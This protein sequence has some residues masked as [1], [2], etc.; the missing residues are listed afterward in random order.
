M[1]FVLDTAELPAGDRIE[2]VHAAMQEASAPCYVI[3]EDP[4]G[5]VHAL[6]GVWELG[7][8][9]IFTNRASGIRLSRTAKQAKQDVEPVVALSVQLLADGR[10]EQLSAREVVKPGE[11]MAMDLSAPYEFSWSGTG[12]AGC[13]QIRF[14]QLGLPVDVI[15]DATG[16]LR[17]SPLNR[18]F[19]D[20][21]SHLVA[22]AGRLSADA[23]AAA[24]GTATVELARALLISAAHPGRHTAEVLHQTL[25]TRVR[26]Y[27][28]RHLTDPALRPATIAAAH[29]VSLRYL[30]KIC[31]EAGF[32]L[33]QWIIGERLAGARADLVRPSS[34]GHTIAVIARRWGFSDP[35]HFTRRFRAAYDITPGEWR[36][37]GTP[38]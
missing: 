14:E 27:V 30:Y 33:E 7:P 35:T 8:A 5:D 12:A 20:H 17:A 32:S 19:T 38:R 9:N 29:N 34:R 25:L 21:V 13:V 31:A 16:N 6:M 10:R 18:L 4:G 3:H 28:R 2:A 26:A 22:D 1:P 15:R 37:S 11:L 23:G 36:R 24:L